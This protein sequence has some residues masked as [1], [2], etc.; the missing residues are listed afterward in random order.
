MSRRFF[1]HCP[2]T[3][4]KTSLVG[5]EARHLAKSLRAEIGAEVTLFDGGGGEFTA[6]VRRLGRSTI[7]LDVLARV[8]ADRELP[9]E[10]ELGV[11]LPKGDRQRWLVEKA[12]ELGVSR[13][14]P[15]RTARGVAQPVASALQRLR[16]AVIEASKQCGRNRLMEVLEPQDLGDYLARDRGDSVCWFAHPSAPPPPVG[17]EPGEGA[18]RSPVHLAVGPEGG[19]TAEEEHEARSSC[20]RMVGLG[21]RILRTETAAIALAALAATRGGGLGPQLQRLFK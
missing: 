16:R 5:D 9:F 21:P 14:I 8:D 11:A 18:D 13:L 7:E 4:D 2:I 15:L 17:S 19:F 6:R 10:L 12:V 3:S 20:W 1:V